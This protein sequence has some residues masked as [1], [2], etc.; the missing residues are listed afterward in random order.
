MENQL[1]II[2]PVISAFFGG[3]LVAIVN[4]LTNKKKIDSE[5]AQRRAQVEKLTAEADRIRAETENIRGNV[6]HV[7]SEQE[8]V[9]K[10]IELQAKEI[11]WI[12]SLTN[13]LISKYEYMH[14]QNLA[15]DKPFTAEVKQGST[16]EWELRHLLTLNLIERHPDTGMR[17]LFRS[18]KC[19]IKKHLKIAER[20]WEYLKILG[21]INN[22]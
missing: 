21:E 17:A 4:F 2:L 15:S 5:E 22:S 1:L 8:K 6:E 11:I 13:L 12:R 18:G 3:G 7:K 19:D 20:G 10:D 16:F 14:L 9:E